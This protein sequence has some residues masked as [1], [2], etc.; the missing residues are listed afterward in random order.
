MGWGHTDAEIEKSQINIAGAEADRRRLRRGDRGMKLMG[1]FKRGRPSRQ[2]PPTSPGMYTFRN[3]KTGERD[4]IGE[5]SNLK[6]RVAK[7]LAL[8]AVS[9]VT[10]VVEWKLADGR[11]TSKTRRAHERRMIDRHDPPL[12]R[13]RGGGGRKASR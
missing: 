13:R 3:R 12:N 6:L 5:T 11:S 7:H 4:Y 10:H 1:I 2:K 9:L 8:G